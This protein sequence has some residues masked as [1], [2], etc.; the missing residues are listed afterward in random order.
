MMIGDWG[1]AL[2]GWIWMGVWVVA[3]LI[4]VWLLVSNGRGSDRER[5]EEPLEILRRRYANGEVSEEEF[6]NARELLG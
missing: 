4:M 1:V 6:R 3:L 2:G 5:G